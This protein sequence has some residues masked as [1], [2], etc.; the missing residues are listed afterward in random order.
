MFRT[1]SQVPSTAQDDTSHAFNADD[2]LIDAESP[3]QRRLVRTVSVLAV[4]VYAL[5]LVYRLLY[6]INRD[7]LIFSSVIYFA[8]LHGFF[9]LCLYFHSGWTTRRRRVVAP[10]PGLK[11]DVFITTYDED[12]D[13]LRKTVRA[14]LAMRYPHRTYILDDG[15]R[16]AVRM[17]AS[18]H[19]SQTSS[20]RQATNLCH[21]S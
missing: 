18:E 9:S 11:V 3:L 14:A 6:T 10:P 4:V 17:M 16:P 12:V 2:T 8:E 20:N 5:Y 1:G 19:F 15:R 13:L 7:A 21:S